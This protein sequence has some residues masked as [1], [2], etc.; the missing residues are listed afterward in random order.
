MLSIQCDQS[1]R[2]HR[3][4]EEQSR[5]LAVLPHGKHSSLNPQQTEVETG[6]QLIIARLGILWVRCALATS[7]VSSLVFL[8]LSLDVSPPPFLSSAEA[9]L[10]LP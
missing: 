3:G 9:A 7:M 1:V 6:L 2:N 8:M 4:G 5:P 10:A